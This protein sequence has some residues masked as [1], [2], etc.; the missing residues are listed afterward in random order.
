MSR[1]FALRTLLIAALVLAAIASSWLIPRVMAP[2]DRF[3][4][5][6]QLIEDGRASEAI[7]LLDGAD[8]RGVAE[9]RAGRYQRALE[10]FIQGKSANDLYNVGNA[11]ARL[12]TWGGAK[13]AY[14]RALKLDPGH[15]DA[16]FNLELIEKAEAIEKKL[17][18]GLRD[19]EHTGKWKDGDRED[20]LRGEEMGKNVEKGG[21]EDG[22]LTATDEKTGNSGTSDKLGTLGD[23]PIGEDPKTGAAGGE[24][25]EA[26]PK[27][28]EAGEGQVM[29]ERERVQAVEVLLSLIRDDP[30]LVLRARLRAAAKAREVVE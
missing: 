15:D 30:D 21:A 23:D 18:E 17:E 8:W 13:S 19:T 7:Y 11:Y 24:A 4:V 5:A 3:A 27:G 16:R 1:V 25:G 14:L 6:M 26:P 22:E 2:P 29:R 10:A 9:Y 20:D 28:V 12:R